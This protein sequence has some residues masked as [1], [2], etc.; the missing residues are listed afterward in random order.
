R[1]SPCASNWSDPMPS[2]VEGR[3]RTRSRSGRAAMLLGL[4]DKL[5]ALESIDEQLQALVE[6]VP[7]AVQADRATIFLH[8]EAACEL[9]ARV[10]H[11]GTIPE[12]RLPD[13][14]GIIGHV[15]TTGTGVIVPDAYADSR[16]N[17]V[18][19]GQTGY[20]THNIVCAPIKTR[21]GL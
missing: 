17:A 4:L 7:Q 12:I 16:F 8:D 5:S 19:D 18:M 20:K 10:W 6:A 2:K 15:F 9:Y 3:A 11:G 13:N 14:T 21:R 1:S